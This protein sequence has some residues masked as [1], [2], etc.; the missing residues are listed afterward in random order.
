MW[1]EPKG[2]EKIKLPNV[3]AELAELKGELTEADARITLGRF[4]ENNI[5]FT[6]RILTGMIL[7]PRQVIYIKNWWY[8][9]F[10]L[11]IWGRGLGKSTLAGV[12]ACLYAIFNPNTTILIVS[13]NFRSSR[14]I[15]ESIEKMTQSSR[16]ILLK[17][18]F[19]GPMSRRGDI[20]RWDLLNGSSI[21]CVPLSNGEGLRGL[22]AS[23]LI[24][25]EAL[26]VPMKIIKEILQPFLVAAGDVTAKLRV[27]EREDDLIAKGEMKEE[28]RTNF[29][30]NAKMI[31]LSSASYQ[32]EDLYKI[33]TTYLNNAVSD[34]EEKRRIASYSVS[35]ISFKAVPDGFLDKAI[36]AD[37]V[38]GETPESI[39]KKEYHAQFIQNSESYYNLE[40]MSKCTIPPGLRPCVEIIGEPK[41]EYVLGIDPS[42][43]SAENSDHFSMR[44]LKIVNKGE[45]KI[46]MLV[47]S[48]D[49][50]GGNLKD[51]ILYLFYILT[52]FNV[53]YI[54]IDSSGGDS[55]EFVSS[56]NN[57]ALFKNAGI[58]LNDIEADFN[59]DDIPNLP[60]QI[61]KSYSLT[62]RRIVQKQSFNS[63]FQRY[64]NEYLQ[65]CIEYQNIQFA[66]KIETVDGLGES[67]AE[68][69][70]SIILGKYGVG[71]DVSKEA[72]A[73]FK[74][75]GIYEFMEMQGTA[76][77]LTKNECALIEV[78]VT[79]QGLMTFKLPQA[80]KRSKSTDRARKDGYSALLVANWGLRLYLAS[81]NVV[82][83]ESNNTFT[84]VMI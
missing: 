47:H 40:K 26:L 49:V 42:F 14:R 21:V 33:Y 39:I 56:C 35:Q 73:E 57:S 51:H 13:Q 9:N 82:K 28:D 76:I 75:V 30:T 15:L 34:S 58:E 63:V 12:F 66:G 74:G 8:H 79:D 59:K 11:A 27:K 41:A 52:R 83:E 60:A 81:Q 10:N 61:K 80:M 70:L 77:D 23:V 48:Y 67:L 29:P 45:K 53:V 54:A 20:F 25:D 65:A 17:Q 24:V 38:S 3:N 46:G 1:I 50:A 16:G 36:L 5:A 4:L 6:T 37:V 78:G 2:A 31:L 22:R 43:S 7:H 18:C 55:N 44:L 62:A 19:S 32:W 71:G 69:D 72:H 84:P 68:T 64:A